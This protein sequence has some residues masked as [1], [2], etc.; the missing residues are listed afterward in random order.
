MTGPLILGACLLLAGV[1]FWRG[2][3]RGITTQFYDDY[4]P[5]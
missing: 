1:F 4:W 2:S 3:H 5:D